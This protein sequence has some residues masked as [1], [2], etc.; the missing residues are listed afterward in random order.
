MSETMTDL[1]GSTRSIEHMSLKDWNDLVDSRRRKFERS[2]SD[3]PSRNRL[4]AWVLGD[5]AQRNSPPRLATVRSEIPNRNPITLLE[6]VAFA[7]LVVGFIFTSIKAIAAAVPYSEGVLY[8]MLHKEGVTRAEAI[9]SVDP[10]LRTI[11]A[12]ITALFFILLLT[13]SVIYFK[14]LDHTPQTQA[15][16]NAT[17]IRLDRYPETILEGVSWFFQ[18]ILW[19]LSLNWLTPRLPFIITYASILWL[20]YISITGG[21]NAFE[22]FIPIFVEVGLAQTV[23]TMI[24]KTAAYRLLVLDAWEQRVKQWKFRKAN[25][26]TDKKFLEGLFSDIRDKLI[27]INRGGQRPNA[28]LADA[29]PQ[30]V[31]DTILAEYRR[32]TG[33]QKFA[34]RVQE[35]D[36]AQKLETAESNKR[37]PPNDAK[38]WTV[39]TLVR[40]IQQRGVSGNYTRANIIADYAP[41]YDA[42]KAWNAGARAKY[43]QLTGK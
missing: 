37:V 8:A 23:A 18:A 4:V 24:E 27:N 10:T 42:V 30:I 19:M 9:A 26:M 16:K 17:A 11:F 25:Y 14:I 22:M 38:S 34:E 33:G 35:L 43:E 12:G 21:G 36:Y 31:D 7:V 1:T 40:D 6:W 5:A 41:G 3:A 2:L 29:H 13:P 32:Y 15:A 20:C 28:W 39:E